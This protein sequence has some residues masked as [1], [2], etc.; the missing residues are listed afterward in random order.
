MSRS[1]ITLQIAPK[2]RE[3]IKEHNETRINLI[4]E[5]KKIEL[6]YQEK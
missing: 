3:E 2:I 6:D 5:E 1:N 4:E